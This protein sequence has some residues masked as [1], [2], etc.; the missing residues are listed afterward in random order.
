[1]ASLTTFCTESKIG[2]WRW[3]GDGDGDGKCDDKTDSG[4]KVYTPSN[5]STIEFIVSV[6]ASSNETRESVVPIGQV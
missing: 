6:G 3:D 2:D 1:M 5:F 4:N